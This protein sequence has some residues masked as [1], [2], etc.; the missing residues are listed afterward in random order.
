MGEGQVNVQAGKLLR[1]ECAYLLNA[2]LGGPVHRVMVSTVPAPR[3]GRPGC[4][5]RCLIP[6]VL[7]PVVLMGETLSVTTRTES[8][9]E[10]KSHPRRQQKLRPAETGERG[11]R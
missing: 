10:R 8:G 3:G 1:T 4:R 11:L 9:G 5:C 6:L 2:A 7:S